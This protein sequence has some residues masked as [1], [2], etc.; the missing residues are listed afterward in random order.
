MSE[1]VATLPYGPKTSLQAA[2]EELKWYSD[3][4]ATARAIE[5]KKPLAVVN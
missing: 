1:D 3:A 4:L 5:A 2:L